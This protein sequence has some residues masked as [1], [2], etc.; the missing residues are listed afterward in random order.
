M[1][2]EVTGKGQLIGSDFC[3][4][5]LD[6]QGQGR[7][8]DGVRYQTSLLAG[9]LS[10]D[11]REVNRIVA[12]MVVTVV[13]TIASPQNHR[14]AKTVTVSLHHVAYPTPQSS[15]RSCP[16]RKYSSTDLADVAYSLLQ[17]FNTSPPSCN[18]WSALSFIDFIR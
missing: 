8:R 10:S 3:Q 2:G 7:A 6:F 5:Y 18:S 11:D 4:F 15:T 14:I 9:R 1:V 17:Q 13:L 16:L 12:F